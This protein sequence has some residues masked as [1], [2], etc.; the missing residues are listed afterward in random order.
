MVSP[1]LTYIV[2][3]N[4]NRPL[5]HTTDA[6][7]LDRQIT[8]CEDEVFAKLQ[9]ASEQH[10]FNLFPC[11]VLYRDSQRFLPRDRFGM[12][13]DLRENPSDVSVLYDVFSMKLKEIEFL[14]R[15]MPADAR[16]EV[17]A[18]CTHGVYDAFI[19]RVKQTKPF[20]HLFI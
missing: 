6:D 17:I 20:K 15:R 8:Q 5:V 18:D 14:K 16:V 4:V 3:V 13:L 7:I 19:D 2:S 9:A 11:M 1:N 12:S 10:N